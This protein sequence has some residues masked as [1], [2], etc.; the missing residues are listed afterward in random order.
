MA[1]GT[2]K[3]LAEAG[4][5]PRNFGHFLDPFSPIPTAKAARGRIRLAAI[6]AYFA[7]ISGLVTMGLLF[8]QLAQA[9][10]GAQAVSGARSLIPIL[11]ALAVVLPV[12][13]TISLFVQNLLSTGLLAFALIT[14]L[15]VRV[16]LHLNMVA[17][18]GIGIVLAAASVLFTV[19]VAI[20]ATHAIRGQLS[21]R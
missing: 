1:D 9:E 17:P 14:W 19:V 3:T 12:S 2:E 7:W 5:A 21:L 15:L 10:E 13:A 18:A 11:I 16:Y 4:A 6:A 20:A 8:G